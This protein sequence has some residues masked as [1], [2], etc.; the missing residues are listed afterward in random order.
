MCFNYIIFYELGFEEELSEC[1]LKCIF[2]AYSTQSLDTEG[3]KGICNHLKQDYFLAFQKYFPERTWVSILE[4]PESLQL[5]LF[6]TMQ[7]Y[8]KSCISENFLCRI[9]FQKTIIK[10]FWMKFLADDAYLKMMEK[11]IVLLSEL[12]THSVAFFYFKFTTTKYHK[13]LLVWGS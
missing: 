13:M 10:I 12:V 9:S 8:C 6:L 3:T 7:T 5:N 11:N 4:L 2:D 1:S